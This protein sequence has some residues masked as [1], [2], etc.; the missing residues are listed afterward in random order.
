MKVKIYFKTLDDY[1]SRCYTDDMIKVLM[2]LNHYH[3]IGAFDFSL[4]V[5][6]TAKML[7]IDKINMSEKVERFLKTMR[8]PD[9][10]DELEAAYIQRNDEHFEG[11]DTF[12]QFELFETFADWEFKGLLASK[13]GLII[14]WSEA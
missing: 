5:Y 7:D 1:W 13:T 12:P 4:A 9:L 3:I 11:T 10:F 2:N 14:V 8:I 6:T